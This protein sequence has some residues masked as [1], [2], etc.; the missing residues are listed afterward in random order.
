MGSA[1]QEMLASLERTA[2]HPGRES[3]ALA[4]EMLALKRGDVQIM[5]DVA[6]PVIA[7][8]RGDPNLVL[9]TQPV[10][11]AAFSPLAGRLVGRLGAERLM[12]GGVAVAV[13][14]AVAVGV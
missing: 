6:T 2:G 13:A 8:I 10:V 9:L 7:S 5:G 4:K 1:M 14:R 12:A 3:A 11:M